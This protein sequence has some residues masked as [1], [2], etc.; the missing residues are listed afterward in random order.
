MIMQDKMSNAIF[1]KEVIKSMY[2]G[3]QTEYIN[4]EY[5]QYVCKKFR[6]KEILVLIYQ[7]YEN[8]KGENSQKRIYERLHEKELSNAILFKDI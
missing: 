3:T 6:Q 5:E 4:I 1:Y 7:V 2:I 8:T